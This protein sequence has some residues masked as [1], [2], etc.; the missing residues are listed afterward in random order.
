MNVRTAGKGAHHA[1]ARALLASGLTLACAMPGTALAQQ[2]SSTPDAQV[3]ANVL[4][5]LAAAPELSAQDIQSSTVY[6]VVTLSGTV[7]TEAL[8][9]KA[10]NLVARA[11]G[12]KKVVDE[13]S[14][15]TPSSATASA[16]EEASNATPEASS[17]QPDGTYPQPMPSQPA[18][19]Y[20]G[21]PSSTGGYPPNGQ[22]APGAA[23]GQPYPQPQPY[24]QTQPYPTQAGTGQPGYPQPGYSQPGPT[25]PGYS[26]PGY[27][28]APGGP[29]NGGYAQGAP[30]YPPQP[31]YGQQAPQPGQYGPPPA[32]REQPGYGPQGGQQAGVSVVV[33]SGAL[34]RVRI[35]RGLDSNHIQPG[36]TFDGT[37]LSDVAAGGVIAIPRG[38]TV[39]GVV[40]DA[41]KAGALKGEGELSL[42]I[43]SV[44]LGGTTYPFVSDIWQR[45]GPDKS[46]RTV[47][48]ALGLG[49][50]GA[51]VGGVAGGGAGA[52]VGAGVGAG[53]GV[54]GSASS[55][56]G[57]IIV[58]PEA[59]LTFHLA[60]PAQVA[61]VSEQEMQRLAYAAG[62]GQG[63]QPVVRRRYYPPYYAPAPYPY[64]Y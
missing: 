28:Q 8:R 22:D 54:A 5:A 29:P 9:T 35:N 40:V 3:E 46:V 59:V 44:T 48:S 51:I 41:K 23:T 52:A 61:T 42:Q 17:Q 4:K 62:P 33:P 31:G 49:V 30:G 14:L 47:N 12:V 45:Q 32:Y 20:T 16:G 25:Q 64:P 10:E 18:A 24:G 13:L 60:Q 39:Q 43:N 6:G 57:R 56:G 53:V 55:P 2:A 37:V 7:Q 50:L 1:G 34:L 36:A 21:A 26:Q 38:A 27:G 11:T 63:G 19:P 15:G 58:P